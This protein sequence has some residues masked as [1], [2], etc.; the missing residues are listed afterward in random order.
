MDMKKKL[1]EAYMPDKEGRKKRLV[2]GL[3][4]GIN[5]FV[6]A[7]LLKIQKYE[8]IGVTVALGWD[9]I[10][11]KQEKVISCHL[12]QSKLDA[13]KEFC[14]QLGISHVLIK[15]HDEYKNNVIDQWLG[16][17]LTGSK[18]SPCWNCHELRMKMLHQKMLEM[19]AQGLVT[20]HLAK[21]FR[22][23]V[24]HSVYVHSS[25]DEIHDQSDLLSRLSHEVLDSLM[26]PLSD[27]Q[28]KEI[29]KLAE[30]FGL[31]STPSD[32]GM[33]SCL[34]QDAE[35][36]PVIEALV[37][38][39]YLQIGDIEDTEENSYGE[40]TGVVHYQYGKAL[41]LARPKGQELYVAGYVFQEKKLLVARETHFIRKKVF[42]T[43]CK[44]SEETPW[45]EPLKGV[46]KIGTENFVDCWIYPKNLNSAVVEL[47]APHKILEGDMVAI[48]RK[49]GKNSKVFLTGKV[50]YIPEP[51]E[52]EGKERVK[53]DYSIDF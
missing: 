21:L 19:E 13:I 29:I 22:H 43:H 15:A 41:T 10:K 39:K 52:E 35:I 51:P 24:H 46:L 3:S 30:N 38:K 25:N 1:Q 8:L 32:I 53:V 28:Q 7:Y 5:S 20:G 31:T 40:H 12:N 44:I 47:E 18:L 14:Q 36:D 27:L 49:K 42:L 17:K 37:P 2:V 48:F 16:Q 50:R 34:T 11:D 6:A 33:H 23:E 9:D 4:G 45:W 26:L